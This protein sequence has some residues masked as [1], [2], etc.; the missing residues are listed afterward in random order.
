M[1]IT[2]RKCPWTKKLF[3]S[4]KKYATHLVSLR[5]E[6]RVNREFTQV[7]NEHE[8]IFQWA[9]HNVRDVDDFEKWMQLNWPHLV[10]RSWAIDFKKWKKLL[11]KKVLIGELSN[12]S[13]VQIS[14]DDEQPS[15]SH[16]CPCGGVTNFCRDPNL[17]RS[18]PGW[19][20]RLS[21]A[22]VGT[23]LPSFVSDIF[24]DTIVKTGN[25]GGSDQSYTT[26][27]T[28]WADDWPAM[29]DVKEKKLM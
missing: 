16:S 14:R 23:K 29:R 19:R 26:E 24:R 20:F 5:E 8:Q 18:Y 4:D 21:F 2:V 22:F 6:H 25:G 15:N 7:L 10:M 3:E 27:I 13:M 12:V 11:P 1:K 28:L 9:A 17:P